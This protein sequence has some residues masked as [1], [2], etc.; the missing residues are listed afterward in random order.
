[1]KII[2]VLPTLSFGDAVGND[3]LAIR[4]MI[5]G[6][7]Y[8]TA[9]YADRI[10]KRLPK[11]SGIPI[12]AMPKIQE[13]DVLIYHGSTGDSLNLW[14]TRLGGRKVMRYHNV[15]PPEFFRGYSEESRAR[16]E[17]GLR[18]MRLSA[19]NYPYGIS[20]SDFN[21][22]DLRRLGFTC[23]I[24]TCPIVIPFSDYEKEPDEEVIR[25]YSGDGYVNLLFVGR[26]APNKK[27]ENVIRAFA[28]Y[29]REYEK[30][31]R[32]FLVGSSAGMEGYLERLQ[33]YVK[34]L[35]IEE[36]VI[37][38][39]QISF[40][41]ILAYYRIADV[42]VCMSEHEGFCVPIVEAMFFDKPIVALRAAAIPETLGKAGLLLEDS[43]PMIAA[44]AINRIV[45][46]KDLQ[47]LLKKER[48]K[49]LEKYTYEAV[50]KRM[51]GYIEKFA[52]GKV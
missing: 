43:E 23:P 51:S 48:R 33:E 15:T 1:M 52:N 11:D 35:G 22:L 34:E 37:F 2:Q 6:M 29:Q 20:V 5:R 36:S 45:K 30:K 21:R 46:D 47:G 19:W 39:G 12:R 9:I 44:A 50:S 18:E 26:I 42:F 49:Q 32:L 14:I 40:R 27:Q 28:E 24:D 7:G 25:R 8:E 16:S 17:N 38:P 41:A 13:E 10:D 3:V 4:D 31:S